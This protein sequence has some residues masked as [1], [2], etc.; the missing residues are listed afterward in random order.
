MKYLAHTAIAALFVIAT[1]L[2]AGPAAAQDCDAMAAQVDELL[3]TVELTD[4]E[5]EQVY[6]LRDQGMEHNS[7]ESTDCAEPL[8]E[9]LQILQ[10]KQ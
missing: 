10:S 6:Q 5:K 4:A 3:K 7:R 8:S 9:A 2:S 1:A